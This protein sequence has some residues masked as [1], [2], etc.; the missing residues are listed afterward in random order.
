MKLI[1]AQESESMTK[2]ELSN[3]FNSLSEAQ[4]E[5][6]APDLRLQSVGNVSLN[7]TY[8]DLPRFTGHHRDD[9]SIRQFST[10]PLLNECRIATSGGCIRRST[11]SSS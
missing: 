1:T 5:R 4:A 8:R 2:T 6:E 3:F 11:T 10:S 7:Y 9:M